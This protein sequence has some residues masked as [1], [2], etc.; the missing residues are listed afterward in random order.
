MNI[1]DV[2]AFVAVVDNGSVGKAAL[3]LN[4]T[5]P[6]ISRRVQRLEELLGVILLD[7][8]S[9]PARPTRAGAAAYQ[10]CLEVLRATDALTR[11]TANTTPAM[12]LRVGV[13]YAIAECFFTPALD[14]LQ[15]LSPKVSLHLVAESSPKLR[16][17]VAEGALDA[18]V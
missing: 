4:L 1:E 11:E 9:K 8:I 2:R 3:R 7:R 17:A 13:S 12:P 6:A 5:Q 18:A 10:R 15:R 14:A 16:N